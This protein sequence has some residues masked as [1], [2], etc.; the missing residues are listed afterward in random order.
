MIQ[1]N[2]RAV[3][4]VGVTEVTVFGHGQLGGREG[5]AV[6]VNWWGCDRPH[7]VVSEGATGGS[8][9]YQVHINGHVIIIPSH[10]ATIVILDT[11]Y[12]W[13]WTDLFMIDLNVHRNCSCSLI[14]DIIK[15]FNVV[16]SFFKR[17]NHIWRTLKGKKTS[18]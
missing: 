13:V 11:W 12:G 17:V 16:I 10:K 18:R 1:C 6:W 2:A 5:L 14:I 4:D 7:R 9:K 3:L 8:L 15:K